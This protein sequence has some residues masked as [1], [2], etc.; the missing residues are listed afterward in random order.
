MTDRFDF[1][2]WKTIG[3]IVAGFKVLEADRYKLKIKHAPTGKVFTIMQQ[4]DYFSLWS[5]NPAID[6]PDALGI[7]VMK[8][9]LLRNILLACGALR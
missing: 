8:T 7:F 5:S 9:S 4:D 3:L 6:G 1:T 2:P